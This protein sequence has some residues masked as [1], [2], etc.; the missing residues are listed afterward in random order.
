MEKNE[1]KELLEKLRVSPDN[2]D[3]LNEI[4]I[5]YLEHPELSHDYREQDYFEKAYNKKKTVKSTHNLAC[6]LFAEAFSEDW[7]EGDR[8][9][10]IQKECIDL[11]PK[12]YLPYES[13][14]FFMLDLN[15]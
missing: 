13:Y 12:S 6:Y 2:L 9:M 7:V 8:V 5:F 11:M 3:L 14:A 4:A 15:P 10:E 1:E